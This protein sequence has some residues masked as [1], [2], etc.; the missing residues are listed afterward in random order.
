MILLCSA[1][2]LVKEQ[3]FKVPRDTLKVCIPA[4]LYIVQN[5]L[6]YIAASHLEAATFMVS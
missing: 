3:V 6:F 1:A 5:N 4:M 2:A